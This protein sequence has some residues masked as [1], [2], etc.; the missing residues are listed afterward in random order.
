MFRVFKIL[1]LLAPTSFLSNFVGGAHKS[2]ALTSM[3]FHRGPETDSGGA[4]LSLPST[5]I[6]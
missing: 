4:Q 5:Q 2:L 1:G 6:E 3:P